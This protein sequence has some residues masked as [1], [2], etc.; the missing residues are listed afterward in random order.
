MEIIEIKNNDTH[1]VLKWRLTDN[2]N[3][4]C[5]YCVRRPSSHLE[6]DEDKALRAIPHIK[7]IAKEM[8]ANT[9]KYVK[10]DLIGGE[11]TILKHLPEIIKEL[12]NCTAITKINI[13]TNFFRDVEYFKEL[14]KNCDAY[15]T[16][17]A[18]YHPTQVKCSIEEW[19]EKAAAVNE[20]V[21][22]FKVETV[23]TFEATHIDKFIELAEKY[24]ILYQVEEDIFDER[25][26][27]KSCTKSTKPTPRYTVTWSDGTSEDYK[28]RN[29][30]LKEH[31]VNGNIIK[32]DGFHCSRNYDYL[33]IEVDKVSTCVDPVIPVSDYSPLKSMHPCFRDPQHRYCT[34]CGNIS[35][36]KL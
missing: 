34:L 26:R 1:A 24:N 10:V 15:L 33:Y 8:R 7:R 36:K 25:M 32:T 19:F 11:V 22:F 21:D 17:T 20:I 13:T 4:K 35:L 12:S 18:S 14:Y 23:N 16:M 27:G 6:Q 5:E 3:Y 9:H 28:T 29:S 2:C 31:A 30:F